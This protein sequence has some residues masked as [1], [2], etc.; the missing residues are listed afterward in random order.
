MWEE[1][2]G[3][4]SGISISTVF[5]NKSVR[6]KNKSRY[7]TIPVLILAVIVLVRHLRAGRERCDADDGVGVGVERD[8]PDWWK[9]SPLW[10]EDRKPHLNPH[11][12]RLINNNPDICRK[13]ASTDILVMVRM[14]ITV[15][16]F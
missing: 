13:T 16:L 8:Q 15:R 12:Y 14:I 5:Y 6:A 3:P 10:S 2:I 4:V 9:M 11:P 1:T 7:L